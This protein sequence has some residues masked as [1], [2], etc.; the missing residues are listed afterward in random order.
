VGEVNLDGGSDR[1]EE[2]D[3]ISIASSYV[4]FDGVPL[5][6]GR[7]TFALAMGDVL[8]AVF[9]VERRV[10]GASFCRFG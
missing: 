3:E 9:R 4:N 1:D 5:F 8:G 7:F 2:S 10:T 6:R